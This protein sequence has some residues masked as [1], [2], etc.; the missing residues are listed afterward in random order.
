MLDPSNTLQRNVTSMAVCEEF[1]GASAP[2]ARGR[3]V[4]MYM[5]TPNEDESRSTEVLADRRCS[6]NYGVSERVRPFP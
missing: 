5:R 4:L 3:S 2:E 6:T 1:R